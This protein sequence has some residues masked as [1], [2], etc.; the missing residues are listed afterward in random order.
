MGNVHATRLRF[1]E[2]VVSGERSIE[3]APGAATNHAV[4]ALT[5]YRAGRFQECLLRIRKAIRLSPFFPD[6]FLVPLGEGYRGTGQL[7]KAREVFEYYAARA[8]GTVL[9]QTR[10]ACIHAE[11]GDEAQA[12]AAAETVLS[13][14]PGFSA[15]RFVEST[16]FR[17]P[18][19]REKFVA[20]LLKAGLPE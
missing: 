13:L 5:L 3:L 8:P 19:E 9:S 17:D 1:D 10:L 20:G 7:E 11:L 18:A 6:W 16:Q 14:D 15:A 12:R 2:A 4:L